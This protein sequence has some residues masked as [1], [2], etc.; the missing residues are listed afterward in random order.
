MGGARPDF[1]VHG[2]ER[3]WN[4]PQAIEI[5]QNGL[6]DRSKGEAIGRIPYKTTV[7]EGHRTPGLRFRLPIA[8]QGGMVG[9]KRLGLCAPFVRLNAALARRSPMA[10]LRHPGRERA[11]NDA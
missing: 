5:A 10:P 7:R 11:R 9:L 8:R 3:L 2:R 6:G 1:C 4:A